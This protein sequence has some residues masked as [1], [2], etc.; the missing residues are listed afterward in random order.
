MAAKTQDI[1]ELILMIHSAAL[2]ATG[3]ERIANDL[4]RALSAESAAIVKPSDK[5]GNKPW[6]LPFALDPASVRGYAEYWGQYDVWHLASIRLRRNRIGMVN[7][8]R[9]V[10]DYSELQKTAYYNEY[11]R[12]LNIETMMNV[13]LSGPEPDGS[14]GATAMSFYRGRGG[15]PFS[16]EDAR[17]MSHL[18]PHLI[19]AAQNYWAAQSLRLLTEAHGHALDSLTSAVLGLDAAGR[20]SFANQA[21]L[22]AIRRKHW[23]QVSA[24]VL[25]PSGS[26]RQPSSVGRAL[27]Q[28]AR[29]YS[30]KILVTDAGAGAQ[31]ILCGAPVPASELSWYPARVTTLVWLTPIVPNVSAAADL[32]MMFGLSPAEKRLV[33]RLNEGDDVRSAALNLR[34][35]LHTA[36]TQLKSVFAKTGLRTQSALLTFLTRLS[37]LRSQVR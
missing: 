1:D 34:I 12:P 5:P 27:A 28:L 7:L 3:W 20:V 37:A 30:F 17:L 24:G 16:T 21:A 32:A 36:R 6:F 15:A 19:V 25:G 11:M 18:A 13:C 10:V 2:A 31:A 29:G 22:E 14:F 35:S 23:V 4:R 33:V 9:E 8:D 26:L